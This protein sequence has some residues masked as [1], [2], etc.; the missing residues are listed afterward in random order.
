MTFELKDC[1]NVGQL[2]ITELG[3]YLVNEEEV[4]ENYQGED[5]RLNKD[6]KVVLKDGTVIKPADQDHGAFWATTFALE[7]VNHIMIKDQ[8]IEP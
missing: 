7:D 3:Y 8:V 1:G 5:I 4:P 2:K 6:L